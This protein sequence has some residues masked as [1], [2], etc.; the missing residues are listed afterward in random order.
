MAA[1]TTGVLKRAIET[2]GLGL[3]VYRDRAPEG[4]ALPYIV[5]YEAISTAPVGVGSGAQAGAPMTVSEESQCDLFQ[6]RDA[7]VFDLAARVVRRLTE[8]TLERIGAYEVNGL[9]V[10][11]PARVPPQPGESLVRHIIPV[12][13]TRGI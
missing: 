6:S 8:A 13:L 2:G 10:G 11:V 12:T 9:R 7:E 1:S 3:S 5:V 4:A